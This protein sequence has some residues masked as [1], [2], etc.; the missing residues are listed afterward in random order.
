MYSQSV[1]VT[2]DLT[3]FTILMQIILSV[4]LTLLQQEM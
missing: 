3:L 4:V 1:K 2:W